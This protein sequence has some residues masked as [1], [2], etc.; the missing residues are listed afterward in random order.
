M[1]HN[2]P[3]LRASASSLALV[4]LSLSAMLPAQA[5]QNTPDPL[6]ANV[7]DN[8]TA[9]PASDAQWSLGLGGGIARS[10]YRGYG[11]QSSALP[12]LVYD[13]QRLH[14][15]GTA[16]DLKLGSLQQFDFTLR[17]QYSGDGYQSNDAAILNN[18]AERK[19]ALWFGGSATWR[20]P[21]A[22]LTA[23]WLKDGSGHSHGQ[24]FRLNAERGF[25]LGR[26]MLTPHLGVT[27][28]DKNYVDYY[29]GVRQDEA[30]AARN[31]YTGKPTVNTSIGLRTGL[32]L[33]AAQ[34][35]FLD[36]SATHLGSG[37]TDSPLVDR[38]TVPSVR[39]GYLYQF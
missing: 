30:N 6:S 20:A 1:L 33:S 9:Q 5:Q 37:I 19:Y 13:S 25:R 28:Y 15:F 14:F 39:M 18:M 36:A 21:W 35:V 23:Q 17:A 27:W 29:Y 3:A 31:A 34:S 16:A 24:T 11:Y 26:V 22:R 10:P 7:S 38:A 32:S 8:T 2:H 12:L 4:T